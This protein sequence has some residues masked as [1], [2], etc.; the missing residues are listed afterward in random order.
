MRQEV[1]RTKTV[2]NPLYWLH[3]NLKT[4]KCGCNS[5]WGKVSESLYHRYGCPTPLPRGLWENFICILTALGLSKNCNV[6]IEQSDHSTAGGFSLLLRKM[7]QTC[8]IQF[9]LVMKCG[10]TWRDT[11]AVRN[12]GYG[13]VK[14]HTHYVKNLNI[15]KKLVYGVHCLAGIQSFPS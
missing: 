14:I 10:S 11:Q 3:R 5:L 9:I 13:Q 4:C 7:E 8:L 2:G 15:H 12:T 6:Q 1:Y